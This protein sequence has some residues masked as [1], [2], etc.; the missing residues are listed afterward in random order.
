MIGLYTPPVEQGSELQRVVRALIQEQR[1]L[2][3]STQL[4]MRFRTLWVA[5]TLDRHF[6]HC[7][8][9]EIGDLMLIVQ[10][11]FHIF[12]PEFAICHHARRRLSLRIPMENLTR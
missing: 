10:E 8:D 3:N 5:A 7:T 1:R 9:F 2:A 6:A 4:A 12:E 11:R